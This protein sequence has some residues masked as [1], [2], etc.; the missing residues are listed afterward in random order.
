MNFNQTKTWV[1]NS[2][3]DFS[4]REKINIIYLIVFAICLVSLPVIYVWS[5]NSTDVSKYR[6]FSSQMTRTIALMLVSLLMLLSRNMSKTIK[7][8]VSEMFWF[9]C[10]GLFINAILLLLV[11]VWLF[12]IWDTVT[13][14]QTQFS[15]IQ[16]TIYLSALQIATV[17]WIIL[18][19][20]WS[21]VKEKSRPPRSSN[22]DI[23]TIQHKAEE[24]A[25]RKIEKEFWWLFA[26][27][28]TEKENQN[29]TWSEE[30][31]IY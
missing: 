6:L 23:D 21:F 22:T 3:K 14:L 19:L 18:N 12:A 11:L 9:T 16:G 26:D 8:K 2:R 17:A 29:A 4:L 7:R 27:D 13:M 31:E 10:N 24:E 5:L 20:I 1:L 15:K 25:F 28:I 30:K